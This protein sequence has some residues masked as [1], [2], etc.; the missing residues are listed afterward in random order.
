MSKEIFNEKFIERNIGELSKEYDKVHGAN[1]NIARITPEMIDGL[2]PVQRRILF[3]M[4]HED[5]ENKEFWKVATIAGIVMGKLHPHSSTSIE[6]SLVSMAQWWKNS[7]PLIN[8]SGN[9]GSLAGDPAGAGRYIKAKRSEYC[10]ACFFDD[11]KDSVVDMVLSFDE[12]M[13]EPLYLPA[14]YPNVLLNGCLGIGYGLSSNIPCYN[15][16]EVVEATIILMANRDANIILIPDSPTGADII[17]GD[18]GSLCMR[19]NGQYSQR[20]TYD[21]DA[22]KN[23][24]TINSIP[25]NVTVNSIREKIAEIKEQGGLKELVSMDDK[26]GKFAKVE[27]TIR[28]DVN[29]YKFMKKLINEVA[30][31]EKSYPVNITIV[32][33]YNNIDCSIKDLLLMWIDYR[34]EQTRTVISRKRTRIMTEQRINEVKI[35]LMSKNNL[36]KTI[37]I[38]RSSRNR[39]E[40]EEHLVEEYHNSEIRMDSLQAK[41]LS[42]MKMYE[43]SIESY[44]ECL[45]KREELDIEMKN[46]EDT[47]NT[48]NGIDKV[49]IAELKDGIKK[50]GTDRKSNIVPRKISIS[51]HADGTC[52]LQLSS[53]GVIS[54]RIATNA[55]E[56][57]IPVDSNGF[58]VKVD[59][60]S[61]F[62]LIDDKGYYQLIK[63]DELPIDSRVFVNSYMK[64]NLNG[65]IIAMLPYD[66]ESNKCVTLISKMGNMKRIKISDISPSRRP[67]MDLM[68]NDVII[69]GIVTLIKS[70]KDLLIYTKNGMGQRLDPNSIRIT[71]YMAKGGNGF[72]LDKDDEII[73]CYAINP[74][75][76][77]YL[78]YITTKG[79]MRLNDINFLPIRGSK[80]DAMVRLISLNDRDKLLTIVGCNR[81]D[82][83]RV[84]FDDETTEDIDISKMTES[85]M[86]EE[87]KKMT[88]KNAVSNNIVKVRLI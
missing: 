53:D 41:A 71:S 67:C 9:F 52:I 6:D 78:L 2:K 74:I 30:G 15:F 8:P 47:L 24:I 80:H 86:S 63:V 13:K 77:Q 76:N 81:Y 69:R 22:E 39:K 40:I 23:V 1:I 88:K 59:N 79:K 4:Y 62:I 42:Y 82:K 85:T 65:N 31:L 17:E 5:S 27:L 84:Y 68:E 73:G 87:P 70:E 58:A 11:W 3:M 64:H 44:E 36:D 48:P 16:R 37:K 25:Y 12:K 14:K 51:T 50:F 29:P 28:N 18:F 83:V 7:I 34:R 10:K 45:K 26:S 72:K 55:D 54:R 38:F 35:F 32:N 49:I 46:I 61:S 57:P 20:C 33:D 56:E 21:I 75:E 43:L 19:G 66:I 60:D